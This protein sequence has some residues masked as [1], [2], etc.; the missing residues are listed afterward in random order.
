MID[1]FVC[2]DDTKQREE[3]VKYI[4]NYLL[5]E[6]LDMKLRLA[7]DNPH[8]ITD[9]LQ[10]NKVDRSLYFFDIDLDSDINGLEL[11]AQIRKKNLNCEIVFIT[12]HTEMVFLTFKYQLEALDF[13]LK[14]SPEDIQ[15]R[16]VNAIDTCY[17]KF[18]DHESESEDYYQ[19][20]TGEHIR[21]VR[22][23]DI[24]FFESSPVPHKVIAHLRN[25]QFEFYSTIKE[26]EDENKL[27]YRCHKSYVVNVN[28]IKSINRHTRE[29][30]MI[31]DEK[32]LASV[33]ATRT[34]IKRLK[35]D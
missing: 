17:K 21:S 30:T 28:N 31:N 19:I 16:V 2:E 8:K 13:I 23:Q 9:Y 35:N 20:K 5:I 10:E 7:T 1:V 29:L 12:V 34:L 33:M 11:A 3:I 14:D 4:E 26:I 32:A 6:N 24:L 25:G 15:K 27:F 18:I 22:V